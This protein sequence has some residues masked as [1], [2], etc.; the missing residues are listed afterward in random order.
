MADVA[1]VHS[2]V[3]E[4]RRQFLGVCQVASAVV[5]Y[6]YYQ[7]VAQH[8]PVDYFVKVAFTDG[9][10]EAFVVYVADVVVENAV[11]YA[12][13]YLVV[14]AEV[15][16]LQRVAEV[17]RVVFFPAPIAREVCR[18]RQVDVAVA[19]FRQHVG[20]DLEQLVGRH[21]VADAHPVLGVYI[22]PVEPVFLFLVVEEAIVLVDYFPQGL[23][24]A[25]GR[26]VELLFV[27]A[28]SDRCSHGNG[29]DD[30]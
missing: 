9:V 13:G 30:V 16:P 26:V 25:C 8:E 11:C 17:R 3:G 23:E 14:S 5:A 27:D 29:N 18:P 10:A 21:V 1:H 2:L 24:V 15:A 20:H 28:R 7:A 22:V 12:R 4:A 19:Q 6:V